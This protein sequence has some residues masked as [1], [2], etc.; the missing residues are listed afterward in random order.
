MQ[1]ATIWIFYF[2]ISISSKAFDTNRRAVLQ[3]LTEWQSV[4]RADDIHRM[5]YINLAFLLWLSW[6]LCVLREWENVMWQLDGKHWLMDN[7]NRQIKWPPTQIT[8]S[9]SVRDKLN[10]LCYSSSFL[11]Q[12]SLYTFKFGFNI[13]NWSSIGRLK[14]ENGTKEGSQK[15]LTDVGSKWFPV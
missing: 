2:T 7:I 5:D 11:L 14:M 3:R 13:E 1:S 6:C 4:L 8:A 15:W 12:Y 9:A 10:K